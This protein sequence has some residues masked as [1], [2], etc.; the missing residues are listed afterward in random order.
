MFNG[1]GHVIGIQPYS[2]DFEG[3]SGTGTKLFV[4]YEDKNVT[5]LAV[6]VIKC[7][8]KYLTP[9][10]LQLKDKIQVHYNRFGSVASI[11]KL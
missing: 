6:E 3:R 1:V 9:P 4:T 8:H 5:G 11:E 10:A 7:N 2:F